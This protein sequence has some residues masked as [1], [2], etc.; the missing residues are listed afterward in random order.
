MGTATG[1][2]HPFPRLACGPISRHSPAEEL[3]L[4]A[5]APVPRS[6]QQQ[7]FCKTLPARR[8]HECAPGIRGQPVELD[9]PA[10]NT[11]YGHQVGTYRVALIAD[12][13]APGVLHGH[14]NK[15]GWGT[16]GRDRHRRRSARRRLARP[17]RDQRSLC[18]PADNPVDSQSL[19]LLETA[20]GPARLR[21]DDPI[22]RQ[23]GSQDA[24]QRLLHPSDVAGSRAPD[25]AFPEFAAQR[26]LAFVEIECSHLLSV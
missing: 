11:G 4:A 7:G 22:H 21:P 16:W 26:G 10:A 14:G 9:G 3:G 8:L 25:L 12:P 24:V 2:G 23:L 20:D 5:G 6:R 17:G 13:P 1:R 18:L 15:A 19:L